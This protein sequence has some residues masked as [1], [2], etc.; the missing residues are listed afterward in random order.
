MV[1][2]TVDGHVHTL[3]AWSG[4][5]RGVYVDSGG[6][7]VSSSTTVHDHNGDGS[8]DSSGGSGGSNEDGDG[9]S[10]NES[11]GSGTGSDNGGGGGGGHRRQ[12]YR[13]ALGEGLVVPGLDGVIYSLGADGRLS[14]LTSSAPDLVLEPRMACLTV[15]ADLDGIVEDESC[16]LLIGEKTTELF[17]LDTDTGTARRVGGGRGGG[18]SGFQQ[19]RFGREGTSGGKGWSPAGKDERQDREEGVGDGPWR[20]GSEYRND[21]HQ[22]QEP[23]L[24]NSNLLLQRD[25]YVVRALDAETSKELWFVT[26]AH[27]SALDLQGRGGA[28]ALTRAKVAARDREGYTRAVRARSA[29]GD[30]G[31]SEEGVVKALPLPSETGEDDDLDGWSS[32]GSSSSS[33]SGWSSSEDWEREVP[34]DDGGAGGG[35]NGGGGQHTRR[36]GKFGEE[37]AARFPYLL[38]ENNAHV[39][40][41]DPMDGSVLW[42][43]EMPALAVSL[44]GIRGREWVDILPPPMSMLAPASAYSPA[45]TPLMPQGGSSDGIGGGGG[46]SI[47]WLAG[48]EVDWSRLDGGGDVGLLLLT[49]GEADGDRGSDGDSAYIISSDDEGDELNSDAC[50]VASSSDSGSS[51]F[52]E[53]G[54]GG[55]SCAADSTASAAPED[56]SASAATRAMVPAAVARTPRAIG[57]SGS[58]GGGKMTG[59]LQPGLR[60]GRQ[61]QAQL[62]FLNGHF[63]VSSS[64]RRGPLHA[65][66][67]DVALSATQDRYPHPLGMASRRSF[68]DSAGRDA[69]DG[70][71]D[72]G[73]GGPAAG[74]V[75]GGLMQM[76]PP[77]VATVKASPH[78][79]R[80]V[81]QAGTRSKIVF[82]EDQSGA[83]HG[84]L[85]SSDAV[86]GSGG[87]GGGVGGGG[88]GGTTMG[89]GDW[90]QKLL[91]GVEEALVEGRRGKNKVGVEM[92]PD[93][94][95]LFMSWRFLAAMVSGVVAIVAAVACL[96]YKFGATA[97][98][99]VTTITRRAGS[100]AKLGSSGSPDAVGTDTGGRKRPPE[101][102]VLEDVPS[103][104]LSPPPVADSPALHHGASTS[105]MYV[106]SRLNNGFPTGVPDRRSLGVAG[107]PT[108]ALPQRSASM[109]DLHIQRVHSLPALGQSHPPPANADGRWRN[110]RQGFNALFGSADDPFANGGGGGNAGK[111]ARAVSAAVSG[112]V[113]LQNGGKI[114]GSSG[115]S[116]SCGTGGGGSG[117][118]SA[119]S[120]A[121]PSPRLANGTEAATPFAPFREGSGADVAARAGGL[122]PATDFTPLARAAV[123]LE[124]SYASSAASESSSSGDSSREEEEE[125]EW[126]LGSRRGRSD[127]SRSTVTGAARANAAAGVASAGSGSTPSRRRTSRRESESEEQG[128]EDDTDGEQRR[129][130]RRRGRSRRS[131]DFS[132]GE[133]EERE[134]GGS[135]HTRRSLS[136]AAESVGRGGRGGSG[137]D[138]RRGNSRRASRSPRASAGSTALDELFDAAAGGGGGGGGGCAF[139]SAV[140]AT[141]GDDEDALLVTNRR[142]R[143]E[144]VE[145]QKLGKGGFG[146]VFKC[147]NRL[148]GHDYAVKKIRLSSDPQWKPQL[149]KVLREVK[150]MSLLDHPNI[151]RYYQASQARMSI[152]AGRL[153]CW[154]SEGGVVRGLLPLV[155]CLAIF[156]ARISFSSD[157]SDSAE[158]V[159]SPTCTEDRCNVPAHKPWFHVLVSPVILVC[160]FFVPPS[161][162]SLPTCKLSSSRSCFFR[163]G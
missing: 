56:P 159:L 100:A 99:N 109:H 49:N 104:R 128:D 156:S 52:S 87:D 77:P 111:L 98:A 37:H 13:N 158:T 43:K 132:S 115:S 36:R 96:A 34:G 3:D 134:R 105:A 71:G 48:E 90:R 118:G 10:E 101:T 39:V 51:T 91:N 80:P 133:E 31:G 35:S 130:R 114:C 68:V 162:M 29:S 66:V 135:G 154:G 110:P 92:H 120:S 124:G 54:R 95:G 97:M 125:E 83:S 94:E 17:S 144:F 44:Y 28:T 108:Q 65:A 12:N 74:M 129:R 32:D 62:G 76:P 103:G 85:K 116:S 121:A 19:G 63:Y 33:G 72:L 60:Q 149:D 67:D 153:L 79:A 131:R 57:G 2:V 113:P 41:I 59:L 157:S 150:I 123:A 161:P 26:V 69:R 23:R 21:E 117:A 107:S 127:S 141:G 137:R 8:S 82:A 140:V 18:G 45:T 147:R 152:V 122:S 138:T 151:V 106:G 89:I 148:D 93:N 15:N 30:G 14:V 86:S 9:D 145:G 88:G 24:P 55:G 61:L 46:G 102:A 40:A 42:R 25:E 70:A 27:F 22:Q 1:A 6:P 47:D 16:G 160:M 38:Y 163:R 20:W 84:G 7:L 75:G 139:E 58:G 78:A 5:V 136:E 4:D 53:D 142:L 146:T 81:D 143:T 112:G 50:S 155:L 64:L 126:G 119:F 11:D 73:V